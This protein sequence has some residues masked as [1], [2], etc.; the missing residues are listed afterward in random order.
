MEDV[1]GLLRNVLEREIRFEKAR[2]LKKE[3]PLSPL[4]FLG[5]LKW[6]SQN[7]A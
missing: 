6:T 2:A 1:S 4:F 5:P 3:H 7:S